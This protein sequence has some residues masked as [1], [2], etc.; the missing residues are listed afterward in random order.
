MP[1]EPALR[2]PLKVIGNLWYYDVNANV[3]D[4]LA[5]QHSDGLPSLDDHNICHAFLLD[6]GIQDNYSI[7][8]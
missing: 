4:A 7:Y 2:N 3:V 6:H 5:A 1:L 8:S